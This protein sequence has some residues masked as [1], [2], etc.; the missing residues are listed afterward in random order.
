[1]SERFTEV[2]RRE[3]K[4]GSTL[5]AR[6]VRYCLTLLFSTPRVVAHLSKTETTGSLPFGTYSGLLKFFALQTPPGLGRQT[7]C[8]F[9]W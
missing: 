8:G 4:K 5:L 1:M 2:M 9:T 7:V 3:P 6:I